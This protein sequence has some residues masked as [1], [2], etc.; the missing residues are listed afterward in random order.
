MGTKYFI[1]NGDRVL[2]E[3]AGSDPASNLQATIEAEHSAIH[4]GW[5]FLRTAVNTL[6]SGDTVRLFL[7]TPNSNASTPK[8]THLRS[9]V[10]GNKLTSYR[11]YEGAYFDPSSPGTSI[12]PVNNN[13]IYNTMNPVPAASVNSFNVDAGF[14]V[15]SAGLEIFHQSRGAAGTGF[16]GSPIAGQLSGAQEL[17]LD[18]SKTY[19]FEALSG[20][21]DNI[22]SSFFEFYE[23]IPTSGWV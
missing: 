14:N 3:A 9:Q 7:T 2:V 4:K 12:T 16:F 23:Y 1:R 11:I 13:R 20:D 10:Y 22:V 18:Y 21:D 19:V 5:H 17:V 15:A 8:A 6:A